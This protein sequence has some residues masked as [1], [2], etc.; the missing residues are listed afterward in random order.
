MSDIGQQNEEEFIIEKILDYDPKENKFLIKWEGFNEITWEPEINLE[1]AK[2]LKEEFKKKWEEKR[3]N[4]V[5][6]INYNY[7][8]GSVVL[9]F[10]KERI[11]KSFKDCSNRYP[12]QIID[13]LEPLFIRELV[14]KIK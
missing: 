9:K 7:G 13:F 5:K 11:V 2:E 6:A 12:N 8:K 3:K 4:G 1:N 10:S 14:D